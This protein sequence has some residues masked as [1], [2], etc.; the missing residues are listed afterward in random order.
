MFI[1]KEPY[2]TKEVETEHPEPHSWDCSEHGLWTYNLMH[3]FKNNKDSNFDA[4]FK[5]AVKM[6]ERGN[7]ME[8]QL[9]NENTNSEFQLLKAMRGVRNAVTIVKDAT[10]PH[11]KSGYAKLDQIVAKLDTAVEQYGLEYNQRCEKETIFTLIIRL[12]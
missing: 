7:Q 2:F 3:G 8:N 4:A 9:Q 6:L 11:F 5:E 12:E 1:K 10:N